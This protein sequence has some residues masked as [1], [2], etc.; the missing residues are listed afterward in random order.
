MP[1]NPFSR[2]K[3]GEVLCRDGSLHRLR[4]TSFG[5]APANLVFDPETKRQGWRRKAS[6]FLVWMIGE[7][8]EGQVPIPRPGWTMG[9]RQV[10]SG[11]FANG[12]RLGR[13]LEIQA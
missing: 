13:D 5:S 2:V 4:R 1:Q 7:V 8:F 12:C 11:I 10:Q 3:E 6:I 9:Q